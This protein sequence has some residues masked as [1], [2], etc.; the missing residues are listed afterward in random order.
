MNENQDQ[1]PNQPPPLPV[2]TPVQSTDKQERNWAMFCHL[3]A[4]SGYLIP[5]GFIIGPLVIW[6][7]K[8]E[9]YPLVDDQGKEAINFQITM[10]IC[11][12][13]SAL[14]VLVLIGILLLLA[15]AI[16]NIIMIIVATIKANDGVRYR[17]PFAIRLI[18]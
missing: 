10:T 7:L 5:F 4:L 3:A 13:V 2:Q 18:K 9:E 15:L 16:F 12:I 6:L 14:L 11:F 1:V 8:K 17:Y